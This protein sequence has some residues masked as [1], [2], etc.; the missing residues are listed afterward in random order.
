[1]RGG[2]GGGSGPTYYRGLVGGHPREGLRCGSPLALEF[3]SKGGL[4][5]FKFA[6]LFE[7]LKGRTS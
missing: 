5:G 3:H 4:L 2:G 6:I 7:A 1:M